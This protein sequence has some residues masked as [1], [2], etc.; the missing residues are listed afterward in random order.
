MIRKPF[1]IG[2]IEATAG[3]NKQLSIPTNM[4]TLT[5]LYMMP[6]AGSLPVGQLEDIYDAIKDFRIEV[7]P[8]NGMSFDLVKPSS[9]KRL[10]QR[11]RYFGAT[12][13]VTN[14]PAIISYH[15]SAVLFTDE[16]HR[17]YLNIGC[18]DLAAITLDVNFKSDVMGLTRIDVWCEFDSGMIGNLGAHTRIGSISPK[19]PATG[20]D[21]EITT[22]PKNTDGQ[23]QYQAVH[24]EVPANM[25]IESVT[26]VVNSDQFI[27]R[28]VP[29]SLLRRMQ[30]EADREPQANLVT[31]DFSKEAF[32]AYFLPGKMSDF[33]IIPRFKALAGA[34]ET[35][36]EVWYELLYQKA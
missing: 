8:K 31:I 18:S 19:I 5:G 16:E 23:F 26:V 24:I 34:V 33:K 9:P 21:I 7:S 36:I 10:Y 4:G 35:N 27:F 15:P 20:G 12:R 32:A 11:E 14:D 3:G 25:D 28:E 22:L 29:I 17:A 2:S 13:G 30:I 6:I 1:K